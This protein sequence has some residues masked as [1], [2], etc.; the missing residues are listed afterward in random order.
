MRSV[1]RSTLACGLLAAVFPLAACDEKKEAPP[2]APSSSV[3][4]TAAAPA[5]PAAPAAK[6]GDG[7]LKGTVTL[8]GKPPEMADLNR[9]A[10]PFCAKDRMKDEEV[11]VGKDG[12][13]ANVIV[14]VLGAPAMAPPE[15]DV[16]L[17]Q[18][19]C[20]YRP[21]VV[22]LVAG[23][24]LKIKNSDKTLHNIHTYKGTSTIFNVAQVPN[25]PPIEKKLTEAGMLMKVKCDVHQWM[26][27]Y[28]WV[29][30]NPLFA[31]TGKDGTFE[32]KGLPNGTWDVEAWH[33]RFGTQH[34]KITVAGAKPVEWKPVFSTTP[35]Q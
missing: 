34:G 27:G 4:P 20:M 11:V 17:N 7:V 13:L 29:Q 23:Q 24:T 8:S 1:L 3:A 18:D 6:P 5:A 26:V 35:T 30:N 25:T 2:A 22:A 28:A 19:Q 14:R 9:G 10:D 31:V 33:E 16:E 15:G 32:V 21:R 12:E